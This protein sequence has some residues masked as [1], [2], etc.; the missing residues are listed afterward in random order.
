MSRL[1]ERPWHRPRGQHDAGDRPT[2]SRRRRRRPPGL[3]G[4][5]GACRSPRPRSRGDPATVQLSPLEEPGPPPACL[6]AWLLT[7]KSTVG[8]RRRRHSTPNFHPG[9]VHRAVDGGGLQELLGRHAASRCGGGSPLPCPRSTIAIRSGRRLRRAEGPVAYP[10]GATADDDE[11]ELGLRRR[12]GSSP[13]ASSVVHTPPT[14]PGRSAPWSH[15][16]ARGSPGR[17]H[18]DES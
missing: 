5:G 7:A 6:R 1:G 15:P 4:R 11:V 9:P 8:A 12:P 3:S 14:R 13:L 16:G 17:R 18:S 10:P 2:R